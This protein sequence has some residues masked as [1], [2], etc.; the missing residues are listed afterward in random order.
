M[1]KTT[2]TEVDSARPTYTSEFIKSDIEQLALLGNPVLD[3]LV[4]TV[5]ALS[6]EVWA[7]RRRARVVEKLLAEKG[8]TEEMIE[9]YRP[10]A[11]DEAAWNA[12]RDRFVQATLNPLTRHAHLPLKTSWRE[13]E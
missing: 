10:S 1:G 8:I 5:I 13:T 9:S 3:N 4:E 12:E 7:D 2:T 11:E 6:S